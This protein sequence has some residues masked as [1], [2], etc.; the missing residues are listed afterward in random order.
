ME[1]YP[2]FL[3][4]QSAV[5]EGHDGAA[6]EV[7]GRTGSDGV[8]AA[9]FRVPVLDVC[10]KYGVSEQT[11]YRWRKK[12][13]GLEAGELRRLNSSRTKTGS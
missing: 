3:L 9:G 5:L 12:Y 1:V 2:R 4:E 8:G 11:F 13:G 7:R 6:A 10:R